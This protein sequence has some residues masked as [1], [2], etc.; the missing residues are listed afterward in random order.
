MNSETWGM[1]QLTYREAVREAMREA[2]HKDERVFLMGEDVG[3]GALSCPSV[4]GRH[5]TR[6][7]GRHG[8]FEPRDP[9]LL[10]PDAH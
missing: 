4:P 2:M 7:R 1:Q 10:P 9:A 5:A 6:Y 3:R 8:P